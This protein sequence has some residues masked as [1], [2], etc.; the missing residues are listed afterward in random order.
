MQF[1][2]EWKHAINYAD[3]LELRTRLRAV[4]RPDLHGQNGQYCIRSLYFDDPTDT[5]LREKVN[6]VN[7]R[8]KFRLRYYDSN[9]SFIRLEKKSK[10]NNL[11]NKVS[12]MVTAEQTQK[13]IDGDI[14]WMKDAEAPLLQELYHKMQTK[15][16]RAKT[17][18]EYTREAFVYPP[19]N[20]RITLDY[21]IRTGLGSTDFLNPDSVTIPIKE[22][23]II[24]EVKWDEYLPDI[25]RDTVQLQGRRA[26]AFSKYAACR[27]YD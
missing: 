27:M 4:T 23:P 18:V 6:G 16:L 25:I 17:I 8:E 24:L 13:I 21:H 20:V 26:G 7:L 9:T 12:V 19:G 5:A 11:C 22:D 14:L 10:I 1:R 2:H 15:G 3:M